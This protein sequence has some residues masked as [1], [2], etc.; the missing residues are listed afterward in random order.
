MLVVA[1]HEGEK[2]TSPFESGQPSVANR[3][4]NA[5]ADRVAED[6]RGTVG[7]RLVGGRIPRAVV[8]DDRLEATVPGHLVKDTA[9][10][11]GLVEGGDDDRDHGLGG[12]ALGGRRGRVV[13]GGHSA[14]N[15]IGVAA[16]T[17]SSRG[18]SRPHVSAQ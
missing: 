14:A 18:W 15:G 1:G 9:D 6:E 17:L 4:P 5:A 10:L 8:N 7:P 12:R 2:G 16:P 11:A 13:P 3:R